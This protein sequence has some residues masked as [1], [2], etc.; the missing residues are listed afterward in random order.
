MFRLTMYKIRAFILYPKRYNY[1]TLKC[2]CYDFPLLWIYFDSNYVGIIIPLSISNFMTDGENHDK[3]SISTILRNYGTLKIYGRSIF[4]YGY[5]SDMFLS[6]KRL[7]LRIGSPWDSHTQINLGTSILP[8]I[9]LM[10]G[11]STNSVS[12][13]V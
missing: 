1:N 7:F 13:F 4:T 11:L 10:V 8:V 9:Y 2:Q 3:C 12:S 6:V 5:G